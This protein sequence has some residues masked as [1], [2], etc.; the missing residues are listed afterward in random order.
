M[1]SLLGQYFTKD[2]RLQS[3]VYSLVRN[4][5]S[6][7][8][9]CSGRGDLVN[10]FEQRGVN[11]ICPIEYD[12]SVE[13]ISKTKPVYMDF[14][15][16]STDNK[17][18]TIFGNP[19]FVRYRN[20]D[21]ETIIKMERET[22]KVRC[23]NLFYYFIEKSFY[24][25][26]EN[27]EII[28]IIPREFLNSTRA[29]K[30]RELFYSS[31]TITDLYDFGEEK[32][33][34]GAS[35]NIIIFRYEKDNLSHVTN[36]CEFKCLIEKL[37]FKNLVYTDKKNKNLKPLS[38]FFDVKVGL[39]T[40]CNEVF[41]KPSKFSIPTI[42][43]DYIDTKKKRDIIFLDRVGIE[44]IKLEDPVLA[45]YM[46]SH[47]DK[48]LSRKIKKFDETNWFCYGAVRN[49]DI[50]ECSGKA[51]YV[52]A[53]TRRENPFFVE[54][55]GYFDGSMLCL[56]P[57]TGDIDLEYW[58]NKLNNSREEFKLHNMY[59]ND[60]YIFSVRALSNFTVE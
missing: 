6:F 24:H 32:F 45:I 2:I 3:I 26:N 1:N 28:F 22:G 42:C 27:G 55:L 35:P 39:V 43:S 31:G 48:L 34:K 54:D 47:K 20:I 10:Y 13:P 9:P 36:Y 52:N 16:Y 58:C 53:K 44:K 33:F 40:G 11:N 29:Q 21:K 5:G 12:N 15:D 56:V 49:L 46:L 30:L 57:K 8:E 4:N 17:F 25:L 51:I 50:M 37:S 14:F 41:E 23:C 60:K 19:P 59:V 18:D 38:H 7:L